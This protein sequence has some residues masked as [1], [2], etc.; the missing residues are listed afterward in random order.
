MDTHDWWRSHCPAAELQ[1]SDEDAPWPNNDC[2]PGIDLWRDWDSSPEDMNWANSCRDLASIHSTAAPELP[3]LTPIDNYLYDGCVV[4]PESSLEYYGTW[5]CKPERHSPSSISSSGTVSS[6]LGEK[7]TERNSCPE[8]SQMFET[9]QALDRHTRSTSHKAWKCSEPGCKKAYVRRDTFLRHRMAHGSNSH[10]C[11]VCLNGGKQ[12][13]FKRKDHLAEH[14]RNCHSRSKGADGARF[15]Q[16][17]L[18]KEGNH[19]D[20]FESS[21]TGN[22]TVQGSIADCRCECVPRHTSAGSPSCSRQQE[23]AMKDVVTSLNTVLRDVDPNLI[24]KLNVTMTNLSGPEMQSVAVSMAGAALAK[25][26]PSNGGC[27]CSCN[28]AKES[29]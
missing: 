24:G 15:V 20:S 5:E 13:V 4:S 18:A 17:C 14:I 11:L 2:P 21:R 23:K 1:P 29:R 19:V 10:A 8:C 28:Q 12:K 9:L 22:A 25:T 16:P 6:T 7:E 3:Y 27:G 26:D